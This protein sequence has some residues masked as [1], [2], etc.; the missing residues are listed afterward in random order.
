MPVSSYAET[1]DAEESTNGHTPINAENTQETKAPWD[2]SNRQ[3]R[4]VIGCFVSMILAVA[5]VAFSQLVQNAMVSPSFRAPFTLTYFFMVCPILL[6]PA[7]LCI[8]R[9]VRSEPTMDVIR[10]CIH[11]YKGSEEFHRLP[12]LWKSLLFCFISSL[13]VYTYMRALQKLNASDCTAL[14]AA[15][16]SFVYLLS[17]IVLF[18][19]FIAMRIFAMIFSITGIVLFAY[20]D[21]FGSPVMFGVVMGVASSA[22]AAVYGVMYK[23]FIGD[24]TSAQ[25]VFFLSLIGL[26]SLLLLWPLWL[27][28]YLLGAEEINWGD[29]P[30][31]MLIPS[32]F[33]TVVYWCMKECAVQLTYQFFI[34]LGL[35]LAIPICSVAD[36]VW[37]VKGFPGMK[38]A[39]LVLITIGVILILLPE[40]WHDFICK[41]V[42]TKQR[43]S[44]QQT[45][46]N[47]TTLRGRLSRTSYM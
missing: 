7:Y 24:A 34:G 10:E 32:G 16:H 19:K 29:V 20:V 41:H 25:A 35:V 33:L 18:E 9:L 27:L 47:S 3:S 43:D 15:N 30:W 26:L 37:K 4:L 46:G 42:R 11:V 40:N 23:K 22:G 17:W 8:A 45:I 21:G 44:E 1:T 6:F 28:L 5:W 12:F 39:A 38:I 14:F 31:A 13:T 36:T 2:W